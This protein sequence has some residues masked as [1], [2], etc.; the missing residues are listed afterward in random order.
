MPVERSGQF[1]DR[2]S[3]LG[4]VIAVRKD[5]AEQQPDVVERVARAVSR[6]NNFLIAKPEESKQV[7]KQFFDNIAPEV[8][9]A[10]VDAIK[11]A[12]SKDGLMT[13][14]QWK[15]VVDILVASGALKSPLDYK[16]GA[17]WTNRFIKDIPGS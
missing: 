9:S 10:S 3:H 14:A 16:E 1:R 12:I 15:N 17:F 4:H 2:T 6:A 7:L 5:Y 11:P 8:M 13:E